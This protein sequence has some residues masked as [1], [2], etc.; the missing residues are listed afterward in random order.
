M[1]T[2]PNTYGRHGMRETQA[3][4]RPFKTDHQKAVEAKRWGQVK[5]GD[6]VTTYGR[7]GAG[8]PVISGV[9]KEIVNGIVTIQAPG[10]VKRTRSIRNV[11]PV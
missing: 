10:Y 11:R 2:D 1:N 7:H 9:V 3:S 6:Q 5:V 4:G 8:Q